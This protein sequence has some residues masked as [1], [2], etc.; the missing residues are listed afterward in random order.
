M[1]ELAINC[2]SVNSTRRKRYIYSL[3]VQGFL[4]C[5][6]SFLRGICN[7]SFFCRSTSYLLRHPLYNVLKNIHCVHPEPGILRPTISETG[8]QVRGRVP[9][10]EEEEERVSGFL[11]VFQQWRSDE[12]R[13][14]EDTLSQRI[15]GEFRTRKR[16][17]KSFELLQCKGETPQ[18]YAS[19]LI[20]L[21]KP[22]C[23]CFV[24]FVVPYLL[25]VYASSKI[26]D[27]GTG[28]RGILAP[29]AVE[30]FWRKKKIVYS[31]EFN[32]HWLQ[33]LTAGLLIF[34]LVLLRL[35]VISL[36]SP[37]LSFFSNNNCK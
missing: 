12:R 16:G 20:S 11:I 10:E 22:V 29:V 2:K 13:V 34:M 1:R 36:C 26:R 15:H 32:Y 37:T 31:V 18:E 14:R 3:K 35:K 6:A 9:R 5:S 7:D 8:A 27:C 17:K 33:H 21:F 19:A 28:Y 24:H 23:Q 4:I 25:S 30:G